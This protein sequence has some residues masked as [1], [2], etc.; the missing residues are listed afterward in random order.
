[1]AHNSKDWKQ[2]NESDDDR[3]NDSE[4]QNERDDDRSQDDSSE[5]MH[6][7][8]RPRHHA[9][10]E[11]S[12]GRDDQESSD[13][14]AHEHARHH[15]EHQRSAEH[16]EEPVHD[17]AKFASYDDDTDDGDDNRSSR[18]AER[19][20]HRHKEHSEQA[21]R[22]EKVRRPFSNFR[23][24]AARRDFRILWPD[25]DEHGDRHFPG[26]R[27]YGRRAGER[28]SRLSGLYF[29]S[30][31][32]PSRGADRAFDGTGRGD[33][34]YRRVDGPFLLEQGTRAH[35][36]AGLRS[37]A[38]HVPA[39]L[40]GRAEPCRAACPGFAGGQRS[41]RAEPANSTGKRASVSNGAG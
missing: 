8:D 20:A 4:V 7:R 34:H 32:P 26:N 38:D 28:P 23:S 19:H 37:P 3:T 27:H 11:S 41:S 31:R 1:M 17:P 35:D 12:D 29:A 18:S 40:P 14:A 15:H 22:A 13:R 39:E 10:D 6:R 5:R 24:G 30:L 21:H 2:S 33:C 36:Q 9:E 16:S 25:G